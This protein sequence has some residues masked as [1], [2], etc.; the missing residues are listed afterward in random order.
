IDPGI[1]F[2]KTFSHN[3]EIL[4]RMDEY[5]SLGRPVLVGA[6]RKGFLRD[7]VGKERSRLAA[8]TCATSLLA[9]RSGAK[10]FRVHDVG[11]H[12]AA[13]AVLSKLLD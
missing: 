4:G 13:L 7:L 3:W 9:A 5:C 10:I 6:S 8:A 2:G 11:E 12:V 1:G